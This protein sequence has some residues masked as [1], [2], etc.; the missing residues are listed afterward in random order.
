LKN[1]TILFV[2]DETKTLEAIRRGLRREPYRCLFAESGVRALAV[3]AAEE[4]HVI[5]C[6]LKMPAMNG[7]ELLRR[8]ESEYSKVVKIILSGAEDSATLLEAINLGM[9]YSYI[10]KPWD[11]VELKQILMNAIEYYQLQKE[12]GRLIDQLA[13]KNRLLQMRIE[14]R[15]QEVRDY[16]G[17]AEI[18]KYAAQ[19]VHNMN[20]PLQGVLCAVDLIET[21]VR[22]NTLTDAKLVDALDLIKSCAEKM[23]GII[24]GVLSQARNKGLDESIE[25]DVNEVIARELEFFTLNPFFQ[26]EVDHQIELMKGMPDIKGDPVHLKQ[27][28]ENLV[29]NAIDAMEDSPLKRLSV[30]TALEDEEIVLRIEDTGEGIAEADLG[31]IFSSDY[32][33]KPLGKGTGLGLASVKEQVEAASWKIEVESQ[34]GRGTSFKVRIPLGIPCPVA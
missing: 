24:G 11:D 23:E 25:F 32:S 5:V 8:I 7:L 27:I 13:S 10:L 33:T 1:A 3:M 26:Y 18:G 19:I 12:R 15:S 21:M 29:K 17:K 2:D 28:L 4:V 9:V 22:I 6:D 20:N 16:K 14:Q 30:T 34:Q 31:K